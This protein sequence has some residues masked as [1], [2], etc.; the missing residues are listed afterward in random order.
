MGYNAQ[1]NGKM[2]AP[3]LNLEFIDFAFKGEGKQVGGIDLMKAYSN[4]WNKSNLEKDLAFILENDPL[5]V[6]CVR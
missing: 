5:G 2:A 4:G 1:K 6:L 3:C